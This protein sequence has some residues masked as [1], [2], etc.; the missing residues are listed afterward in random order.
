MS[1]TIR[2]ALLFLI[3]TIFDIYLFILVLRVILAWVGAD[4]FTPIVQFI[5]KMTDFLVKP[6]R[7]YIPNYRSIEFSTIVV[8]LVLEMIKFF[9]VGLLTFGLANII[10]LIIMAF[11]DFLK[12]VLM[13]FF[14]AILFQAILSWVQPTSPMNRVL[15]QFTAPILRPFQRICPTINGFDISPIPALIVLQL[16]IMIVVTPLMALGMGV[17]FA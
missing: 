8:I 10:G 12:L 15:V 3:N 2:N 14:Y 1:D 11:S 17:A 16:L 4:Y 7:R 13:A 6:L 5:V 9:I